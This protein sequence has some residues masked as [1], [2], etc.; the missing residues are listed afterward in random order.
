MEE[1]KRRKNKRIAAIE[2]SNN[3]ITENDEKN[4]EEIEEL[5][6]ENNPSN[7]EEHIEVLQSNEIDDK[8]SEVLVKENLI[9]NLKT[10]EQQK[11]EKVD[12]RTLENANI[13]VKKQEKNKISNKNYEDN[14]EIVRRIPDVNIGLTTDEAEDRKTIGLNNEVKQGSTKT[15][16][17]IIMSNILTVFNFINFFEFINCFFW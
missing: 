8:I 10:K 14:I 3:I 17:S 6:D 15:I 7:D 16:F 2:D 5:V 9:E 11:N 13:K 4:E 1:S 12:I